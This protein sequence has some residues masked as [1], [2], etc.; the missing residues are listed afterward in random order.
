VI[1]LIAWAGAAV[2]ATYVIFVGGNWWGIYT[3]SLRV[4]TVG[5]AA[6]VLGLWA[7][8]AW[9]NP[10][11]RPRTALWPAVIAALGSLTISTV[12]S[13]VPRVSL[14]YL[15][16]AVVLAALYLLLVRLFA[17]PFFRQRLPTLMALL[18][19]ITAGAFLVRIAGTWVEWWALIGHMTMPP[20]RPSFEGLTFGNPSAVLTMVC[21]LA[22]PTA[23]TFAGP[24]RRGVAVLLVI[25]A[26][27][28]A[29]ALLSGSRAGWLALGLTV[30]V[31]PVAWLSS[32]PNRANL[33][34]A[35]RPLWRGRGRF[36]IAGAGI[37]LVLIAVALAPAV[38]RRIGEGGESVRIGFSAA[39]L[40]MFVESPLAGTGP[41]TWVIQRLA[42]TLPTEPDTYIPHAHNIET[43][44]LAELGIIGALAGGVLV[45]GI[46]GLLRSAVRSGDPTR[47]RWAWVTAAGLVYFVAH[48]VLD[49]YVNMPAFLF[50]ASLPIA[51]L[52]ARQLGA[53]APEA[54]EPD[55]ARRKPPPRGRLLPGQ[56]VA[57]MTSVFVVA[58][59]IAGLLLQEVPAG[60]AATAVELANRG[61]W[62]EADEAARDAAAADPEIHSYQLTAG[63][64]ADRAG[65]TGRA[66]RAFE[67]VARRDD[68]PE[69]WLNLAAEQAALGRT[70]D[71]IASIQRALR[72]GAQR[73]AVAMP[74]GELAMRLGDRDLATAA[75]SAAFTAVPS[76]AGDP[77]WEES[78]MRIAA[79]R[80]AVAAASAT[81][82]PEL[83]WQL[84][85]MSGDVDGA[86]DMLGGPLAAGFEP[87]VVRAW[88]GDDTARLR[89]VAA[90]EAS[91]L[92]LEHLEWCA[93]VQGHAGL[94]DEAVRFRSLTDILLQSS[95]EYAGEFRVAKVQYSKINGEA[96][97]LWA[98]FTYRRPA[99]WDILVP[100]LVH[101][102]SL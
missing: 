1:R 40:R 35:A 18:F 3:S 46:F 29:V 4:V 49:F 86:R 76:L 17:S 30:I 25:L 93:R 79:R 53:T 54:A 5:G 78:P 42:Y 43:Q 66:L 91:P 28:A 20:L 23:A 80:D 69:G 96:A 87:D 24:T 77:W 85:L 82:W 48:Q 21:L 32:R 100:S 94:E 31:L 72:I 44:T 6:V 84:A 19:G 12:F 10:A 59:A 36:V 52:D 45:V 38:A 37:G 34:S 26:V 47:S 64:T 61:Q 56:W 2:L 90:C 75:L 89:V 71:A 33:A 67:A 68:L 92:E 95:A 15:G 11:W 13:R 8:L 88:T 60:R 63:L 51:Y 98:L 14:E 7:V 74:A 65:D 16:Y 58:T 81:A 70:D 99:P 101:L 50:A 102:V 57:G 83:R 97:D 62:A 41:G 55:G 22:V 73:P 27:I 9:R 39:A